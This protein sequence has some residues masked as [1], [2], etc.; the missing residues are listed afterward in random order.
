MKVLDLM[1]LDVVAVRADT[2]LKEAAR[3]MV[4]RQ[5]SGLPVL[6]DDGLV[7][8]I[9]TEADFLRREAG[10]RGRL[11]AAVFDERP[12]EQPS[13]LVGGA[14]T[15]EPTVI[16]PEASLTE[17]ARMM[18][19]E[20]VK[21]LP[22]VDDAGMLIGIISRADIVN[23]FTRPDDVIE[24]EIAQDVLRRVFGRDPA[25]FTIEV[26]D[27]VVRIV[28]PIGTETDRSLLQELTGRLDGVVSAVVVASGG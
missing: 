22:V 5:V 26:H 12:A 9:I 3:L 8:G 6:D 1:A 28:G 21:R 27:G 13:T 23:A 18:A 24:D 14:M 19:D 11:L 4:E 20:G 2:T 17:A 25:E 16:Y 15:S 7:I 10:R